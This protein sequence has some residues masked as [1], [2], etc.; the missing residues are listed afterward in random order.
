MRRIVLSI[1]ALSAITTLSL[2]QAEPNRD[3][4]VSVSKMVSQLRT[5][6]ANAPVHERP[7]FST[8]IDS[9]IR[10]RDH[11][12][13]P[14]LN[15]PIAITTLQ[16]SKWQSAPNTQGFRKTLSFNSSGGQWHTN[17]AAKPFTI[18]WLVESNRLRISH[19]S[20]FKDSFNYQIVDRTFEYQIKNDTLTMKRGD[21]L[22]TWQRVS[23]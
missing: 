4:S 12:S 3:L 5:Q 21:Q 8:A 17:P 15:S 14:V 16:N 1:A 9:L 20:D 23:K 19:M 18:N 13:W 7:A 6:M 10:L 11:D 22:L 2:T